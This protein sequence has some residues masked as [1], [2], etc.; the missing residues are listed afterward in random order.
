MYG[1][2]SI[3]DDQENPQ[4]TF[5]EKI[6]SEKSPSNDKLF[7]IPLS[8][9]IL[10]GS[11]VALYSYPRASQYLSSPKLSTTE[12]IFEESYAKTYQPTPTHYGKETYEPTPSIA[13]TYQPTPSARTYQP[14]PL[15]KTFQP[16]P[17]IYGTQTYVPTPLSDID[18]ANT[19][20]TTFTVDTD[21]VKPNFV[22]ILADDLGWNSIGYQEYDLSFTTPFLSQLA[23]R[24]VIMDNYYAQ[25]MCTPS[26][27]SLLTGRYPLSIGM[28]YHM[29]QQNNAVGLNLNETTIA[30][31]LQEN[32]Y[33]TF[34]YGKWDLGLRK[35]FSS[36]LLDF[37]GKLS[38]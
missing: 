27:A 34:L 2:T 5:A 10:T 12:E 37:F 16:T 15:T 28:Q 8:I 7:Y 19:P 29:I 6:R 33:K 17:S 36:S 1:S 9:V 4:P 21:V 14:T 20:S 13:H 35:S 38:N 22:F 26:R 30:D 11:I 18:T 3:P 31:V 24:G 32:G 23:Q 25:E